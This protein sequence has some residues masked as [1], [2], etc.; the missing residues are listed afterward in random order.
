MTTN[1]LLLLLIQKCELKMSPFSRNF[2]GSRIL[3]DVEKGFK[4]TEFVGHGGDVMTIS[5]GVDNDV[6]VSGSVDKTA[7]VRNFLFRSY[8]HPLYS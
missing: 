2:F 7:K 5:L 3:W 4:I 1:S 8:F 6:F